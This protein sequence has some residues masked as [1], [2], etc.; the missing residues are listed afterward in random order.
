MKEDSIYPSILYKFR[1]TIISLSLNCTKKINGVFSRY[2]GLEQYI[3]NFANV[4][5]LRIDG[6]GDST[7]VDL[8]NLLENSKKLKTMAFVGLCSFFTGRRYT[9][10][11]SNKLM[12]SDTNR[13]IE[14]LSLDYALID[15]STIAYI[16]QKLNIKG[17]LQILPVPNDNQA[18]ITAPQKVPIHWK[19]SICSRDTAKSGNCQTHISA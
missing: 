17:K 8:V 13:T 12:D 7:D 2:G 3:S 18:R 9:N 19:R 16:A 11:S 6:I 10:S 4:D 1:D 14:N 15:A 5:Y